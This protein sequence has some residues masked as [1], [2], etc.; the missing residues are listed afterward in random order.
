MRFH[1]RR[2]DVR[3]QR[4]ADDKEDE[5]HGNDDQEPAIAG[6]RSESSSHGAR[7]RLRGASIRHLREYDQR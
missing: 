1:K 3:E 5:V 2:E 7:V 4:V 6:D